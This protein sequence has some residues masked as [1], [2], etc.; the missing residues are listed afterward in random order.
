MSEPREGQK[1]P[2]LAE[3]EEAP[4]ASDTKRASLF[5]IMQNVA[6]N[7]FPVVIA[8]NI[9]QALNEDELDVAHKKLTASGRNN[10]VTET[11]TNADGKA[12][13]VRA[14]RAHL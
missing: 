7:F 9:N 1:Q 3:A 8:R 10:V 13:T 2:A 4:V 6:E 12:A 11:V 5:G 14:I